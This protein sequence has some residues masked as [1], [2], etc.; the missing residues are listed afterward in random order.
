[1]LKKMINLTLPH[2]LHV[3]L[4]FI[5]TKWIPSHC[6]LP[7]TAYITSAPSI[8]HYPTYPSHFPLF[9]ALMISSQSLHSL[10]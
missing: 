1:M 3:R 2:S 8:L 6:L 10:T 9:F 7:P 4:A 5:L